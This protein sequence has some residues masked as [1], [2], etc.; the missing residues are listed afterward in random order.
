MLA[1]AL[2]MQPLLTLTPLSLIHYNRV[3]QFEVQLLHETVWPLPDIY[4]GVVAMDGEIRLK[5]GKSSPSKASK[6]RRTS[7]KIDTT[8]GQT[9][10]HG[11]R[12]QE[13]GDANGSEWQPPAGT[14]SF[15]ETF[16]ADGLSDDCIYDSDGVYVKDLDHSEDRLLVGLSV[17]VVNIA[18]RSFLVNHTC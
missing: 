2:S 13:T 8:H 9:G 16:D 18:V 14:Q 5:S 3:T 4:Q 6:D 15:E 10:K 17:E 7:F 12:S 11:D 1:L